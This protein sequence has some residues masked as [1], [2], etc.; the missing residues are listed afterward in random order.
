MS[1]QNSSQVIHLILTEQ[2]RT[3]F[4]SSSEV[5]ACSHVDRELIQALTDAGLIGC[6]H[7]D[8]SEEGA[9]AENGENGAEQQRYRPEDLLILRRVRRLQQELGINPAGIEIILRLT[10]RL[11]ALQQERTTRPD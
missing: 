8:V 1:E 5:I 6:R 4:Y 9:H 3:S 11:E 10:A 7:I 2:Q